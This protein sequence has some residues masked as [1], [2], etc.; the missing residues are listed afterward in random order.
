SLFK[1]IPMR[2]VVCWSRVPLCDQGADRL[3]LA[4]SSP[5]TSRNFSPPAS[6]VLSISDNAVPSQASSI[7][8]EILRKPST[9]TDLRIIV[10]AEAAL[11]GATEMD[12]CFR[13]TAHRATIEI[14][15]ATAPA[16]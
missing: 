6:S 3:R 5:V 14:A 13:K 2:D 11:L 8:P 7:F 1:A 9:A 16:M 15:T 10:G 4:T 12:S